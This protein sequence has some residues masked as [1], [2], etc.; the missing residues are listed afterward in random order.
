MANL[1]ASGKR[2]RRGI[3]KPT[4]AQAKEI[5]RRVAKKYPKPKPRTLF[6]QVKAGNK[7]AGKPSASYIKKRGSK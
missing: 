2:D 7:T 4:R 3:A 5:K 6:Q 1:K